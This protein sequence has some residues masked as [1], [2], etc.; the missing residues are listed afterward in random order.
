MDKYDC[1]F[2]QIINREIEAKIVAENDRVLAFLDINPV[3]PVHVLIVPKFHMININDISH[4]NSL[5]LRDM[6]L[7]A[8]E[9]AKFYQI[10][11][12]GYRLVINN[13]SGAQQSVFHLHAHILGGRN[14]SW[15]PG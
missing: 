8:C 9:I 5:Y 13:E 12:T 4:E 10:S 7:M 15:P 6:M 2:C 3:A 1:L 14:F 11:S